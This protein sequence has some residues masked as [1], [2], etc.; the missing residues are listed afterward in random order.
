MPRYAHS[1]QLN[2]V[3]VMNMILR[4]PKRR[5]SW[6]LGFFI[7]LF[8]LVS[9]HVAAQEP[10]SPVDLIE[11]PRL[12][13]PSL[14]PDGQY[15]TYRTGEVIWTEDKAVQRLRLVDLETG[16]DRLL[17][18]PE[19][20]ISSQPVASWSPDGTKLAMVMERG[21]DKKEQI[22]LYQLASGTLE[23]L[24]Q[25][26]TDIEQFAWA[27]D[28]LSLYFLAGTPDGETVDNAHVIEAYDAPRKRDIFEVSAETGIITPLHQRR[29]GYIRNFA[30]NIDG[31]GLIYHMAP[32]TI[33]VNV[34]QGEVWSLAFGAT[35]AVRL[36]RN[37]FREARPQLSPDNRQLAYIATVN[38]R[39]QEYYEDNLFVQ[40]L[41]TGV[42]RLL[43]PDLAMEVM[44]FA[45]DQTGSGL[46]VLGN[47]G[48]RQH[49]YHL[50]IQTGKLTA[51]TSGDSTLGSW[52]Y[53]HRGDK[54]VYILTSA[55]SPGDIHTLTNDE[56]STARQLTTIATDWA[57]GFAL[58][59]QEAVTWTGPGNQAVEG[60]LVYP[61]GYQDGDPAFPLAVITHGG[62]RSSSQFGSWNKSRYVSVLAGQGYGAFLPNHRG[63][64]GYGDAFM[65]DMVG[66]YFT[67][68]HKDV[69]TGIDDL[70]VRGLID[71]DRLIAM[72]W[73]AGG[74]MTNKLITYT[75]RFKAASSGAGASDWVS[76]YAESDVRHYRLP[77]FGKAPWQQ[78]VD[79]D[80][81]REQ[82]P[83]FEAWRVTTPTL[84]FAGE[85]DVRVPP[86]QPIM[87]YRAI[88]AAGA[89]TELYVADGEPHN[90]RKPYNQL[91]KI[92]RELAWYAEH[93]L[94]R[95]YV[96]DLP[97]IITE[98]DTVD[99]A[100]PCECAIAE[101]QSVSLSEAK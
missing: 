16:N 51:L 26:T 64:T 85:N 78:G 59:R 77:W 57:E 58:P 70:V 62:P 74:H 6:L 101:P 60:L 65:R 99:A 30:L 82:S 17:F 3:V 92:N 93:V 66:G 48:L 32:D 41:D 15:L 55:R 25:H 63:G 27:P 23:R 97:E 87:M 88:R 75:N 45:W 38:D 28:S 81:Y 35:E 71:E 19:K 4:V 72:G 52:H 20:A 7:L 9:G 84:F 54:H 69:L 56:A 31:S 37:A 98:S 39:G 53:D 24:T 40:N 36:T 100:A 46:F 61:V 43:M 83:L 86:T 73:S 34:H 42:R 79:L 89:E 10:V 76:M 12:S 67:H 29:D 1:Y 95:D 18:E 49:L 22:Y 5:L 11:M 13:G 68:A 14:S 96:Y 8:P 21:D 50:D 2:A 90:F 94:G 47:T 80:L 33:P 91:F 44:D